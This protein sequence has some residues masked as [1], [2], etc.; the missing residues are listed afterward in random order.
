MGK[1]GSR[2]KESSLEDAGDEAGS[3]R[4][5]AAFISSSSGSDV[6]LGLLDVEE[7][8]SGNCHLLLGSKVMREAMEAFLWHQVYQH[9][10]CEVLRS[11]LF[12]MGV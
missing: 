2:M 10:L 7:A 8:G 11:A 3:I 12:L 4:D 1:L 9:S 5:P 6:I